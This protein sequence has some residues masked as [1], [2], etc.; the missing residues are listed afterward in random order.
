MAHDVK[1]KIYLNNNTNMQLKASYR[2]QL[3]THVN[4]DSIWSVISCGYAANILVV[5]RSRSNTTNFNV[6]VDFKK[7]K[8]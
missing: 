2:D 6:D 7:L 8:Y 4:F 1:G 5:V 3:T